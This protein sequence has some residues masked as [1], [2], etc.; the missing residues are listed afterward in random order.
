MVKIEKE[1]ANKVIQEFKLDQKSRKEFIVHNRFYFYSYLY[2]R[3]YKLKEIADLFNSNH[4]SI[5]YG[6]NKIK[7]YTEEEQEKFKINT[8]FLERFL[9]LL[10]DFISDQKQQKEK[11][12]IVKAVLE[13]QEKL[14]DVIANITHFTEA[15]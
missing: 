14:K 9:S 12:D 3:K 1:I 5:L 4:V 7:S 6:I 11:F 8:D 2:K 10:E 13:I 15:N